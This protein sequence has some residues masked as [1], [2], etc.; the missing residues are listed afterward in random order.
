MVLRTYLGNSHGPDF[1]NVNHAV[2]PRHQALH[3]DIKLVP[4]CQDGFIVLLNP[5]RHKKKT[6]GVRLSYCSP[7]RKPGHVYTTA[8]E[9]RIIPY[10]VTGICIIF[11]TVNIS[12]GLD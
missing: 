8:Q 12:K 2:V 4:Q 6:A 1:L 5:G 10:K 3:V 7:N 9:T 11:K